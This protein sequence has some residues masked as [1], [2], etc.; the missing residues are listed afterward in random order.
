MSY[1]RGCTIRGEREKTREPQDQTHLENRAHDAIGEERGHERHEPRC[2]RRCH[3]RRPPF[4]FA[5]AINFSSRSICSG[6]NGFPPWPS[7]ATTADS[8]E[9][10]KNVSTRCFTAA[11]CRCS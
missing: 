10:L 1:R 11:R 3:H 5:R 7:N 2:E 4:F 8:A 9:S 6:V